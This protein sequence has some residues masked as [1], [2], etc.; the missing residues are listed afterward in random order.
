[1]DFFDIS[2][3]HLD[4]LTKNERVL[5]DYVVKNLAAVRSKNIREISEECFVSTTTFLRFVRKLGFS[6]FSEFI[7]VIKF[8]VLNAPETAANPFVVDQKQYKEEYL[9]NIIESV[10]V[11]ES[12]KVLEVCRVLHQ[13]PRIILF[14]RG[15][16]KVVA[17]YVHYIYTMSGF[18]VIFPE[19]Y[20]YRQAALNNV[21]ASD[22]IFMLTYGEYDIELVQVLEKI[23]TMKE[24]P[25]VVSVTGADNNVIQNLSDINLYLFTDEIDMNGKDI[26][27]RISSIAI[28]ELILYTYIE[29]QHK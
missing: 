5:F 1:M 4:K 8:T 12:G 10:R 25:Y 23:N 6:G 29:Q 22:L 3:P 26:T 13:Q 24:K 21:K 15:L 18:T 20:Q 11:L 7:T 28:M 27:S 19:D 14:A 9:K 17:Q 16:N 2:N